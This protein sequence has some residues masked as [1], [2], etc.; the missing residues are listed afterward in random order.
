M[1]LKKIAIVFI[2]LANIMILVHAVLPHYHHDGLVCFTK[3]D[4]EHTTECSHPDGGST[5]EQSCEHHHHDHS[6]LEA[7]SLKDTVLRY[8][9][10]LQEN[11]L[12]KFDEFILSA[13]L[14]LSIL[15]IEEPLLEQ[16]VLPKPYILNYIS[17]YV[18]NNQCLRAPPVIIS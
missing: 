10:R 14:F 17:T 2:V 11:G 16:E 12:M 13:E 15:G 5:F 7:C 18:D 6:H 8:D 3:E 1:I 4:V 9:D